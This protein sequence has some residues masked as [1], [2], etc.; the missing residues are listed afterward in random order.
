MR[1]RRSTNPRSRP[2]PHL[3]AVVQLCPRRQHRDDLSQQTRQRVA[4]AADG[5]VRRRVT[6]RHGGQGRCGHSVGRHRH[7]GQRICSAVKQLCGGGE[8]RIARRQGVHKQDGAGGRGDEHQGRVTWLCSRPIPIPSSPWPRPGP[9]SPSAAPLTRTRMDPRLGAHRCVPAG[10]VAVPFLHSSLRWP[11]QAWFNAA[12][13]PSAPLKCPTCSQ[14]LYLLAQ[15]GRR[16]CVLVP[17]RFVNHV[18]LRAGVCPRRQP[19][20]P[21]PLH[22][23]PP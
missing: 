12:D 8:S 18:R 3:Q 1:L 14:A 9:P 22:M 19:P 21:P 17:A 15:V 10:G 23:S 13:A 20:L 11:W 2:S 5:R 16:R 4:G 7:H 6:T